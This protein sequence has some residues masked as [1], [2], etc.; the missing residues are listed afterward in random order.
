MKVTDPK[1]T[2]RKSSDIKVTSIFS[3]PCFTQERHFKI[4]RSSES[5]FENEDISDPLYSRRLYEDERSVA[6]IINEKVS[7]RNI[8]VHSLP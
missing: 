3:E 6:Y 2:H 4:L 8:I 5:L 7:F 1:N